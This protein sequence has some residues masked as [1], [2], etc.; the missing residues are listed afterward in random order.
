MKNERK[1]KKNTTKTGRKKKERKRSCKGTKLAV[2]GGLSM[3]LSEEEVVE[4]E[5][6]CN[7]RSQK[8]RGDETKKERTK[9]ETR[10]GETV[11]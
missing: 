3:N 6:D 9:W 7:E 2:A 1:K 10:E 11:G 8:K 5:A 4:A